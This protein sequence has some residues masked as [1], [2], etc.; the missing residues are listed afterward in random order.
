MAR[1]RRTGQ[2]PALGGRDTRRRA[3][4]AIHA[5]LINKLRLDALHTAS[6]VIAMAGRHVPGGGR[7]GRHVRCERRDQLGRS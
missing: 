2:Q 7:R 4:L 1:P 6:L 3:E 5:S